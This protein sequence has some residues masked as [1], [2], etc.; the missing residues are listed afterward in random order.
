MHEHKM[1]EVLARVENERARFAQ[2]EGRDGVGFDMNSWYSAAGVDGNWC[3]TTACLA[4]H[5][6]A[7]EGYMMEPGTDVCVRPDG[8]TRYDVEDEAADLLGL[9]ESEAAYLFYVGT[10]SEVYQ[11]IAA[12]MGLDTQVLRDKVQ[13]A[14]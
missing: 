1:I 8:R 5:A 11:T 9:D 2:F 13:A 14:R 3:G 12:W 4:G 7:A 10:L 6:L